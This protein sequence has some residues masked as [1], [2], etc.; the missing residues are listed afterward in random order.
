MNPVAIK[1]INLNDKKKS[2]Y[3]YNILLYD[4]MIFRRFERYTFFYDYYYF[5]FDK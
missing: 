3:S 1:I 4:N 5:L 2:K